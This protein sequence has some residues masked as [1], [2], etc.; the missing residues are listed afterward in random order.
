MERIE[1]C[2]SE[3]IVEGQ[4]FVFKKGDQ[5]L[6]VSR[7]KGKVQA[8]SAKCPHLGLSMARGKISDG[9]IQCPWHGSRFDICTGRNVD[10]VNSVAGIH[11][12]KWSHKLLGL[13]KQ[14]APVATFEASEEK[15]RVFVQV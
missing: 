1:V 12:P 4:P 2:K 5:S 8:I 9:V 3:E 14:P 7:I 6:I 10:W 15:G 13:G 11:M